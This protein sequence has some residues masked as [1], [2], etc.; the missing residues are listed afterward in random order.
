M[1]GSHPRFILVLSFLLD[2]VS[3]ERGI[4]EKKKPTEKQNGAKAMRERESAISVHYNF[5][6]WSESAEEERADEGKDRGFK[7]GRLSGLHNRPQS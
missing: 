1:G 4:T 7:S 5:R 6:E 2:T 3:V